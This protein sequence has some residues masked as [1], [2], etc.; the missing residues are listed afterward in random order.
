ML[1]IWILVSLAAILIDAL[2]SSFIFFSFAVGGIGA[3]ILLMFNASIAVQIIVFMV[4]S[5]IS[6]LWVAPYVRKT[7]KKHPCF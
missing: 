1:Y 6:I 4:L 7:L 2:T 3:L 5:I